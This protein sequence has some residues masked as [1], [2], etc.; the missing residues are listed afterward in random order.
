VLDHARADKKLYDLLVSPYQKQ[1][2]AGEHINPITRNDERRFVAKDLKDAIRNADMTV[3]PR[4]AY[5]KKEVFTVFM[6]ADLRGPI[7]PPTV[8]P[9][10][11]MLSPMWVC[12]F[13]IIGGVCGG[14]PRYA[15]PSDSTVTI[16]SDGP[17]TLQARDLPPA[18]QSL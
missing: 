6:Y 16:P 5:S 18:R 15:I 14:K 7:G 17:V 9:T 4:Y 3:I 13:Y 12:G 11:E 1:F 10:C 8:E 2:T